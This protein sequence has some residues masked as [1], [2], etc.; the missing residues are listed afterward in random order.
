MIHLGKTFSGF[1][2]LIAAAVVGLVLLYLPGWIIDKYRTVNE[3]SPL[4]GSIYLVVVSLGGILFFGSMTW[5][6]WRLYRSGRGKA[7]AR[8]RGE[9]NP[10]ELTIAQQASEI[11]QNLDRLAELQRRD[12]R[13]G[14]LQAEIDP[15][16][17]A[18]REKRETLSLEIIAFGTISSGKSSVLNLLA[19][20]DAF[21]TDVRGGTTVTRNEIEWKH[22]DK[23]F[24]V[25]TPGLGEID[26]EK[27]VW[28]AA[29]AAKDAD[30]ILLVVDGPL[31][32][33]EYRLLEKLG[34]MEKRIVVCLNKSDWYHA[35]DR[36]KLLGQL[37]AQTATWVDA[38]DV[39]AIQA[40]ENRRTR[41]RTRPDGT[42]IEETV[43]QPPEIDHLAERMMS[44][45]KQDRKE[46]VMANLLMQ[47]RGLLE[48]ARRQ[49]KKSLD[50]RAWDIVERYM[51]GS[52][53]VAAVSPFPLVDLAAGVGISTKMILDLA[54]NYGHTVDLQ[55]ASKWLAEMGKILVSVLG[56]QGASLA[57]G[58]IFASLVKVVPFAGQLVG[59]AVQGVIQALIT[60]W[61][62][63]VFIEYFGNEMSFVDGGLANTARREWEKVMELD[64]LRKLV[65]KA[66]EKFSGS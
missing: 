24:L 36:D 65:A 8:T 37:R 48:K 20:R 63:G 49:I 14:Q 54:E 35:E 19:G 15:L 53:G 2:L 60:R 32:D 52:A 29:E 16:L 34:Q 61:I 59:N 7:K 31:R 1:I 21:A 5:T 17:Q 44:I 41:V 64:S 27:H 47:S 55:T 6:L 45:V 3:L 13:G 22:F 56:S 18:F 12:D 9:K 42:Q 30:L 10:S 33:S 26:G 57:A 50:D 40:Q 4:W 66:R 25:D 23:V 46:L 62:G 58:A 38:D 51:W 11:D 43:V 39:V 28:I